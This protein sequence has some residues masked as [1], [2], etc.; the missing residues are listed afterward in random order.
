M[1]RSIEILA[2]HDPQ[3]IPKAKLILSQDGLIVFPTDTIYGAAADAF[4]PAGPLATTSANISGDANPATPELKI[5]RQGPISL[6][7]LE[8]ALDRD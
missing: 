3:S 7:D 2:I 1:M 8:S 6:D 5:L 4:S